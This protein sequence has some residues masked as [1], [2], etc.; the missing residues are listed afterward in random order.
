MRIQLYSA[1]LALSLIGCGGEDGSISD[2]AVVAELPL[3]ATDVLDEG[4]GWVSFLH[5]NTR[6]LMS[7]TGGLS[8]MALPEPSPCAASAVKSVWPG[9]ISINPTY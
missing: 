1:V 6:Y 5:G 2:P 3:A 7:P 8:P 4:N 9:R